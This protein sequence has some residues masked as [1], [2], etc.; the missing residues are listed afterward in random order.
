NIYIEPGKTEYYKYKRDWAIDVV[1]NNKFKKD[2]IV[3]WEVT[4]ND[5]KK[6]KC[7]TNNH[8]SNYYNVDLEEGNI[9]VKN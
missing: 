6:A 8:V 7:Q 3:C 4:T 1:T 9:N 5:G 2:Y